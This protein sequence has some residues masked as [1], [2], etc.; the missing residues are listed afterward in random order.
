M[1]KYLLKRITPPKAPRASPRKAAPAAG[2]RSPRQLESVGGK[3]EC[4]ISP[5]AASI[6]FVIVDLPDNVTRRPLSLAV[7][8]G[9]T[10]VGQN[11][12]PVDARRNGQGRQKEAIAFSR[13]GTM[14]V[15][16]T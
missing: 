4:Y 11:D 5:S 14:K 3:L 15:T 6:A 12:R 2:T 13:S 9:S 7:N 8:Q 10:V 1:P 16:V